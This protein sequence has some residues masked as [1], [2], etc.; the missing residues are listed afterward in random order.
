M[1]LT[2]IVT[3][4]QNEVRTLVFKGREKILSDLLLVVSPFLRV[5]SFH[6]VSVLRFD[7][8]SLV[9]W[10]AEELLGPKILCSLPQGSK[11]VWK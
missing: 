10:H 2:K 8:Q 5:L 4:S 6:A 9:V 7:E 3:Q 1:K 11:W